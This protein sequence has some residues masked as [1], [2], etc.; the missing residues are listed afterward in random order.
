MRIIGLKVQNYRSIQNLVLDNLGNLNIFVGKNNSGKSTVLECINSIMNALKPD[1]ITSVFKNGDCHNG[2]ISLPIKLGCSLI[3]EEEAFLQFFSSM[4]EDNRQLD[5]AIDRL[6]NHRVINVY[7]SSVIAGGNTEENLRSCIEKI[8]IS[9]ECPFIR[10]VSE[11]T[12]FE[13]NY[14]VIQ[15]LVIRDSN[16]KNLKRQ[17]GELQRYLRIM[18]AEQFALSK[19]RGRMSRRPGAVTNLVMDNLLTSSTDYKEFVRLLN[20]EIT[21]TREKLDNTYIEETQHEFVVYAGQ[22]KKFSNHIDILLKCLSKFNLLKESERKNPIDN[23]DAQKLLDLKTN[24]GG[25]AKL[26]YLRKIVDDLLGVKLD[27]FK[28]NN[29]SS[30]NEAEIDIDEFLVDMNGAGIRESLRLILDIEFQNPKIILLEE[31]E[32]HLHFELEKKLFKYLVHLSS[33]RQIFLTTHST[34]FI[35]AS[36]TSNVF[37]VKKNLITT[38]NALG[39]SDVGEIISDL[40]INVSALLLSKILLFVEGPTDELIIRSYFEQYQPNI[41]YADISFVRMTGVGNYR[42]YANANSL[43]IL[44]ERGLNSVFIIDSDSMNDADKRKLIENHP[45]FS[46]LHILPVRCIENF[47]L[48]PQILA[49]YIS[50][51]LLQAGLT[52]YK[53]VVLEDLESQLNT[54]VDDLLSETIR[55]CLAWKYTKPIYPNSFVPKNGSVVT[56]PEE[57]FRWVKAAIE[58]GDAFLEVTM[59]EFETNYLEDIKIITDQWETEKFKIVPGDKV[60]DKLCSQYGIR[61]HKTEIDID[62]LTQQL[63]KTKWNEQLSRIL[64]E[65]VLMFPGEGN[66]MFEVI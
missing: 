29:G 40:G 46:E 38:V 59:E 42:Y 41:S 65:I 15:E 7:I 51:K 35:D 57:A 58:G 6:K 2:D 45:R 60:I 34:G 5:S 27:A 48:E 11:T 24:R 55:L 53:V 39:S 64:D 43:R 30:Q 33:T 47:F 31:P 52:K 9:E 54:I 20:E 18:D 66:T 37:L 63:D 36:G 23:S 16:N 19:D 17:I 44:H 50:R 12:L 62:L 10:S 22:T 61:Y 28:S 8:T 56:T 1:I 4:K 3:L 25:E 21:N 14:D 26:N 13:L 32:I 49:G